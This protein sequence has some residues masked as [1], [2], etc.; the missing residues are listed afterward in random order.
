MAEH[1]SS[2]HRNATRLSRTTSFTRICALACIVALALAGAPGA[3]SAQ[4]TAQSLASARAAIDATANRWFAA[5]RNATD[6][7]TKIATLTS[8]L[9]RLEQRVEQV[10]TVADAR[11]VEL[12]ESDSQALTGVISGDVMGGD[13]LELGRRAALIGQSNANGQVAIDELEAAISDLHARR[14]QLH[15]AKAAQSRALSDLADRRRALDSELG[16][17][18]LRSARA[19]ARTR[20]AAA[21]SSAT[22]P[23]RTAAPTG[24]AFV[25]VAPTPDPPAATAPPAPP[26]PITTPAPASSG[27]SPH[28]DEPFLVCTRA[29]ESSGNYGVVSSSGYYGA[30]Q[31]APTTWNVT[32]T[33]A[34]RLDLVGVTPSQASEYDQ[35]EMAWTL[36]NWQGNAPWGGRC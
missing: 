2:R 27:V 36:Y 28:H 1:R 13:P 3:S 18:Q 23:A 14:D 19:A 12:Y 30:Y 17:L 32:A 15:K 5:Q 22:S 6:L 21:I 16:S 33:H 9:T 4:T 10:R 25:A 26:A 24:P 34:G 11:A 29:R 8:T 20:L 35:D 31:F 7:D